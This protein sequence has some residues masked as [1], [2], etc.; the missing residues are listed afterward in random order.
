[1]PACKRPFTPLD[2]ARQA[3][4]KTRSGWCMRLSKGHRVR[5]G[6]RGLRTR[7]GIERRI[8]GAEQTLHEID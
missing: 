7:S 3:T 6:A 8:D 1:M 4:V 2:E 5:S